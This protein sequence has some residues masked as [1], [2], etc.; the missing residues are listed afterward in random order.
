M[1]RGM[2]AAIVF[3]LVMAPAAAWSCDGPA[4]MSVAVSCDGSKCTATNMGRTP[5]AVSFQAWGTNYSLSLA[6]G[7]SGSPTTPGWLNVPMRGYQSCTAS[8]VP[9]R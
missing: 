8:F 1:G 6:P 5:V 2:R 9:T 4:A 7:Q 3:A